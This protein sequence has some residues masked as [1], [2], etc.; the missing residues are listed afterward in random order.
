M[1]QTHCVQ[2]IV[3]LREQSN[4]EAAA[5]DSRMNALYG[6]DDEQLDE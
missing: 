6:L 4:G 1:S 5:K 3:A 2:V